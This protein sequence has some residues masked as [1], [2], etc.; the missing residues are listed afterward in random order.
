MDDCKGAK[1]KFWRDEVEE[2]RRLA[3]LGLY[4][5]VKEARTVSKRN[6]QLRVNVLC[7]KAVAIGEEEGTHKRISSIIFGKLDGESESE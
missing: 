4:S 3:V 2:V 1:T 5:F 7:L 6:S